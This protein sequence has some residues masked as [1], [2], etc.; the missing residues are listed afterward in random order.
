VLV[1]GGMPSSGT[2]FRHVRILCPESKIWTTLS[3][4]TVS[5]A[6]IVFTP[7]SMTGIK[8]GTPVRI[9]SFVTSEVVYPTAVTGTTFTADCNQSHLAAE[10]IMYATAG[11]YMG[12]RF[13]GTAQVSELAFDDVA[14]MGQVL[15]RCY[16]GIRQVQ[17]GNAKNMTC[18]DIGYSYI[19]VPFAIESGSGQYVVNGM[20]GAACYDTIFQFG[21]GTLTVIGLEDESLGLGDTRGVMLIRAG[22]GVSPCHATFIGCTLQGRAPAATDSIAYHLGQLTF[23][24]CDIF[25]T[26][27]GSSFP[28]IS[29]GLIRQTWSASGLALIDCMLWNATPTSPFVTDDPAG[30][31]DV[32]KLG[33]GNLTILGCKGGSPGGGLV[34]LPSMI[35]STYSRWQNTATYDPASLAAGT[36]GTAQTLSIPGAALGDVVE[37]SF[38]LDLAGADLRA[39]VSAADTVKYQFRNPT[40]APIDL[41]SGTVKCRVKK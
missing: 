32:I 20:V 2:S 21:T 23:I 37:A 8:V 9:G 39:W 5:G 6:G 25:N 26:R 29:V 17:G 41:A 30:G 1:G 35:P 11:V 7:A 40:A 36:V 31:A 38:S 4:N 15:D 14:F 27:T 13:T 3:S 28:I 22:A 33:D 34:T 24:G 19:H 16:A 18:N 12:N 10:R